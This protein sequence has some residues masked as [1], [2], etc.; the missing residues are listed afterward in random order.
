MQL[1]TSATTIDF[2]PVGSGKR[3]VKRVIWHKGEETEM[4]SFS[5]RVKSD[6]LYD[7][8]QYIANGAEVIDFNLEEYQGKDYSPVYCWFCKT[9]I[10]TSAFPTMPN[11]TGVFLTV[12]KYG[13]VYTICTEGELFY[14]PI[15]SDGSVNFNEFDV[16]YF[17]EEME[18]DEREEMEDIQSALI[19][20]MKR[21]GL[22]FQQSVP[23]W[24]VAHKGIQ[25]LPDALY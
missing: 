8:R 11:F 6:A 13:C 3:F 24:E 4:T 21:A 10:K 15:M 9:R 19:D 1:Q 17:V 5:T 18:D 12:E 14:A 16:F 7:I 22:Y 25:A 20:M 23:V 2:F